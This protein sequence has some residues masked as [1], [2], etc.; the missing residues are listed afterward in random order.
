MSLVEFEFCFR[1]LAVEKAGLTVWN[2][3]RRGDVPK[4]MHSDIISRV[5]SFVLFYQG[6][7]EV[8]GGEYEL[9]R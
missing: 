1:G 2:P 8:I 3:L 9:A 7:W 5:E 6:L 4:S